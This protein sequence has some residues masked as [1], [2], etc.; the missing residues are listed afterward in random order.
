[1]VDIKGIAV[2]SNFP[3]PTRGRG[4]SAP[5]RGHNIL[6]SV[7]VPGRNRRRCRPTVSAAT[8]RDVR[9]TITIIIAGDGRVRKIKNGTAREGR[10]APETTVPARRRERPNISGRCARSSAAAVRR[11]PGFRVRRYLSRPTRR[12]QRRVG[13]TVSSSGVPFHAVPRARNICS[14]RWRP[15]DHTDHQRRDSARK[16]KICP[17]GPITD[18]TTNGI[19]A[20]REKIPFRSG[21]FRNRISF[22]LNS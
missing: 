7:R 11:T 18:R 20:F 8:R 9:V 10:P 2:V 16:S 17:N 3:P 21:P 15:R 19:D 5:D 14:R 1:M 12:H 6:L 13:A 22:R 4:S